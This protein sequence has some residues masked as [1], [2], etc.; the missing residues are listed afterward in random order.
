MKRFKS[1]VFMYAMTLVAACDQPRLIGQNQTGASVAVTPST[2]G[3][4]SITTRDEKGSGQT[5]CTEPRPNASLEA[6][7][8]GNADI[9]AE[10]VDA[11]IKAQGAAG[12]RVGASAEFESVEFLAHGLFGICQLV[13]SGTLKDTEAKTLVE[14]LINKASAL[15]GRSLQEVTTAAEGQPIPVPLAVSE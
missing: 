9:T 13:A 4:T 3:V 8:A 11:L 6:A 5:A 1:A 12:R 14:A 2:F 15:K 10:Q 7:I